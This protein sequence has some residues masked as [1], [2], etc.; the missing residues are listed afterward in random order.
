M[1]KIL[2]SLSLFSPNTGQKFVVCIRPTAIHVRTVFHYL[3]PLYNKLLFV[4]R[5][6]AHP[7]CFHSLFVWGGAS[8]CHRYPL[9]TTAA[10]LSCSTVCD[11]MQCVFCNCSHTIPIFYLPLL[12]MWHGY[13][14]IHQ[15]CLHWLQPPEHDTHAANTGHNS[16]QHPSA[17]NR[18]LHNMIFTFLHFRHYVNSLTWIYTAVITDISVSG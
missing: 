17:V 14:K 15:N 9:I 7:F 2:V 11:A 12:R 4:I 13:H 5:L 16:S 3:L 1:A 10:H 8:V 6:P 18:N